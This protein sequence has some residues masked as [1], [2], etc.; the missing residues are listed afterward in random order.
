VKSNCTGALIALI[1]LV[2]FPI[3]LT[4]QATGKPASQLTITVD[5]NASGIAIPSDF[6]GLSFETADMLPKSDGTYP[7]FRTSN[8]A[9][10][11][12][13]RTIGV[14]S[15]RIGGNTSD[16]PSVAVPDTHDID[17]LFAFARAADVKVMYT[18]RLRDSSPQKD[19]PL[20]KYLEDHYA[21][22]ISCLVVGN[23]P[24]VYEKEYPRYRDDLRH[25]L[26][27]ILVPGVAPDARICG[28]STTPGHPDWSNNFVSDFGPTG[29]VLWITQHS[30][31]GGNGK[32][33]TDPA[34]QRLRI[35]SPAFQ[36]IYQKLADSFVPAVM[37][38]KMQYRIEETNSFYNG[39]AK[40][41]S[42]T[43]ASSLW[44]LN[45]L[46]WWAA[47]DSQGVNFHTGDFVAAGP[48]QTICWY[49]IF[50]TLPGGEYEI[51]PIAYAMKAFDLT[52]HGTL[53][54]VDGL[55]ADGTLHG[56]VVADHASRTLY[57]T[58]INGGQQSVT[59]T[60]NPQTKY[61]RAQSMLLSA[62]NGD[63]AA[64]SGVTLGG[65][66]ISSSGTWNG[67]WSRQRLDHGRLR[68][69]LQPETALLVKLPVSQ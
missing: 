39:G 11:N 41:V 26:A 30:Y 51:R 32:K 67:K 50:H 7:Y 3:T 25:Y 6:L 59:L 13:F 69:T 54:P 4:A 24:D 47:H 40:Y 36:D 64:T 42:N 18:L 45:Y 65:S 60:L 34:A 55:P 23:E 33:V 68:V 22:D 31:P 17:R 43:F 15:L 9:L 28:P 44:A 46:Y 56:Y 52:S 16:R 21:S 63:L 14:K 19:A 57:L 5:P 29:H 27:A 10:I 58:L 8:H 61:A 53:I 12:L 48:V 1:L 49:G 35:L 37:N 2:A 20:A 66:G 38:A 62:P